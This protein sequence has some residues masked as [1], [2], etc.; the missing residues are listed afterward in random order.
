MQELP[1][2]RCHIVQ[3]LYCRHNHKYF[4]SSCVSLVVCLLKQLWQYNWYKTWNTKFHFK[5]ENTYL[6]SQRFRKKKKMTEGDPFK[7]SKDPLL[8]CWPSEISRPYRIDSKYGSVMSIL[9]KTFH[10]LVTAVFDS[11]TMKAW[12]TGGEIW[13]GLIFSVINHKCFI[14]IN[15]VNSQGGPYEDW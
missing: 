10:P 8:W 12:W 2:G 11:L 14:D 4:L 13:R 1:K 7:I 6:H 15:L 5:C 9:A 3:S